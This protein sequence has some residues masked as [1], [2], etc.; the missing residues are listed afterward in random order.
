MSLQQTLKRKISYFGREFYGGNNVEVVVEPADE[1]TGIVFLTTKGEVKADIRNAR[2]SRSSI[3]LQS[4]NAKIIHV[5]HFLATLYAYGIDN[6][7]VSARR[8]PSRSYRL[9][10]A[11]NIATD[12]DVIPTCSD[13]ELTL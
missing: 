12:I 2:Q 8:I 11:L 4:G 3:M 6:A 10:K 5:E 7:F 1:N 9:L 13:R